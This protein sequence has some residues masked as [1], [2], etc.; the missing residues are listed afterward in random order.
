MV[1]RKPK[2]T[3]LHEIEG[4]RN[5]RK[6]TEPKADGS[7][8]CPKHLDKLAKAEW[9]RVAPRL[10]SSG[11]LTA[12][13]RS[14][15]AAYC[16]AYSRLVQAQE[17]ITQQGLVITSPKSGFPIQNPYVGIA[18]TAMDMLRKYETEFGMTPASRCRINVAEADDGADAFSQF[19]ATGTHTNDT[20]GTIQ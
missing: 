1:G 12:L 2:P 6:N 10:A 13:D 3:A 17:H 20:E 19:M 15:L 8:T 18:N 16:I 5:R 11:L 14:A 7:A 9:K 4:T